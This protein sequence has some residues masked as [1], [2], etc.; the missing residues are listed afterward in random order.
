V[1]KF[2]FQYLSSEHKTGTTLVCQISA[3][4]VLFLTKNI[5]IFMNKAYKFRLYPNNEQEQ[6]LNQIAGSGRWLWN[7]ML[8]EQNKRYQSEKKFIFAVEMANMLPQLKTT[9][10]WLSISPSQSLQQ[11]CI[12]QDQA[13]KKVW[14]SG[15]GFP[16]FKKKSESK[17]AFRIPQ[18]NGHIKLTDSH[19]KIP[20][21]GLVKYKKHRE[22]TGIIKSIT[23]S[24]DIDR[25]FVSV[26]VE[27]PEVKQSRIDPAKCKSIGIDLGISSF[28]VDSNS[29]KVNSPNFLKK[30]TKRL[31]KLQQRLSR[32]QKKS[33]NRKKARIKLAKLHR[34]IRNSRSNWL[35]KLSNQLVQ[36][37]DLICVEDLKTKSLMK[38]K[39]QQ[40]LNREISDQGWGMFLVML[41]YKTK[42]HGKTLTQINQ[43]DPSSK[44][45]SSCGHK[46]E[47]L[48]LSVRAWTCESC[49]TEHDR[50]I[51]AAINIKF[52]G[53]MATNNTAGTAG[54]YACGDTSTHNIVLH[55]MMCGVS[56]KQEAVSL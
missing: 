42:I 40:S 56:L 19:I 9:Y 13:L 22:I 1:Y 53:I 33:N 55:N 6:L 2:L 44:T 38:H 4:N 15:F 25:W 52:W 27:I 7:H 35:H 48:T 37:Y 39:K 16:K 18:T 49:G 11:V 43:F 47:K 20:K 29:N 23:I 3:N 12:D 50:D 24:K 32:K 14:K 36:E 31:K 54:I 30:K 8:A 41:K 17:D 46:I 34:Y 26:L 21:I 28:L 51:N 10:S 5:N 45:C